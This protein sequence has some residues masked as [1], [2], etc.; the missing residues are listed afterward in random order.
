MVLHQIGK[1]LS[2]RVVISIR[3]TPLSLFFALIGFPLLILTST[4]F[5]TSSGIISGSQPI[6]CLRCN[7][8]CQKYLHHEENFP[9][10]RIS[11]VDKYRSVNT[12]FRLNQTILYSIYGTISRRIFLKVSVVLNPIPRIS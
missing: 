9:F 12:S 10:S 2:N 1:S 7:F 6:V 4:S 5:S 11:K 8:D 3:Y